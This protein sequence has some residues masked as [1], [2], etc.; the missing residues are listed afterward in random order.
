MW[1][2][3]ALII[4]ALAG[5]IAGLIVKGRGLGLAGNLI[6]GIVGSLLGGFVFSLLGI[7]A[8]GVLGNLV[9]SVVGAVLLLWLAQY[10]QKK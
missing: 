2:V 4:G 9:V 1:I 6:A 3:Y 5:W 10:L 7:T 8:Y